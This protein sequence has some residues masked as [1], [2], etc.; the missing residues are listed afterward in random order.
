MKKGL[1]ALAILLFLGS[2]V[3]F[4]FAFD[5]FSSAAES[6]HTM[7]RSMAKIDGSKDM[8]EM[9]LEQ[10]QMSLDGEMASKAKNLGMMGVGGGV[11]LLLGSVVALMKSRK[12]TV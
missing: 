11:V 7:E 1:L 2:G 4:A 8:K 10:Y 5:R 9:E 3:A 12:K 6:V